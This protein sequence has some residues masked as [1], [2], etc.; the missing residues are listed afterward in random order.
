[1]VLYKAS[2]A[3]SY[4]LQ[5][6]SNRTGQAVFYKFAPEVRSK[7]YIL[8]FTMFMVMMGF[9]ILFPIIPLFIKDELNGNAR[10][11]GLVFALYSIVQFLCAPLWGIWSDKHGRKPAIMIGVTGIV[12]S[13]ILIA[14]SQSVFQLYIARAIGGLLTAAALPSVFA[15]AADLTTLEHRG[16]AI[17]TIGGSMGMGI[18][19]G[20]ALGGLFSTISFTIPYVNWTVTNLRTPF[21]AGSVLGLLN[22]VLVLILLKETGQILVKKSVFLTPVKRVVLAFTSHL[23][24]YFL[25][26]LLISISFSCLTSTFTFYANERFDADAKTMGIVFLFFGLFGA[27][28]QSIASGVLINRFGEPS[29]IKIGVPILALAFLGITTAPSLIWFTVGGCIIGIAH[30]MTMPSIVSAISKGS[31]VGQ[32]GALGLFDSMEALGRIGGPIIGTMLFELA[33]DMGSWHWPYYFGALV[34]ATSILVG[35]Q[36]LKE[37]AHREWVQEIVEKTA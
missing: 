28:F 1:M 26:A 9:S 13:F 18:V 31:M 33:P 11:L 24:N 15:Y 21:V 8:A 17:A 22:L 20:P 37:V 16:P 35:M 10:D 19:F 14:I 7:L 29:L 27:L 25:F 34:L 36:G 2:P 30:G 23:K 6:K 4:R 5:A 3:I 12:L 32:G